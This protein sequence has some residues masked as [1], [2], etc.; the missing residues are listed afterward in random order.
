MTNIETLLVSALNS[1]P[2][3]QS[4]KADS[5]PK[6]EAFLDVPA[7]RPVRFVTIER[8]TGGEVDLVDQSILAVQFWAESRVAASDGALALA[9]LLDMLPATVSTLGRSKATNIYN[10]PDERQARYQLTVSASTVRG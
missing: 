6:I 7:T 4:L 5:Q 8:T 3:F 10:F 2:S 9:R 1:S